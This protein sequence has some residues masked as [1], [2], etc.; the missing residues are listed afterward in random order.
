MPPDLQAKVLETADELE[1]K[2]WQGR[3]AYIDGLLNQA[4]TKYSAQVMNPPQAEVDK[5]LMKADPVLEDWKQKVGPDSTMILAAINKVL[6]TNY[7]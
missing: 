1:N 2:Q 6:G 3:Q 5:L 7:K 4:E